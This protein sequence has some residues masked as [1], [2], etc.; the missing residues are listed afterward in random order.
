MSELLNSYYQLGV[1]ILRAPK[2]M[3]KD[4]FTQENKFDDEKKL[5]R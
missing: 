1:S 3:L 2:I 5:I 4:C